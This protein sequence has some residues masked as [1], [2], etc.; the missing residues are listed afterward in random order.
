MK[1]INWTHLHRGVIEGQMAQ[2]IYACCSV[3]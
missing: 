1:L 2:S 3:N